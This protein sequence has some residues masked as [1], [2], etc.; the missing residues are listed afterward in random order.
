MRHHV[1]LGEK[2]SSPGDVMSLA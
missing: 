2:T 1:T